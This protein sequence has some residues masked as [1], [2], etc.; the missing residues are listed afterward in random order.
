MSLL[1]IK[2]I[3]VNDIGSW[4]VNNG[5]KVSNPK[6]FDSKCFEKAAVRSGTFRGFTTASTVASTVDSGASCGNRECNQEKRGKNIGFFLRE[7]KHMFLYRETYAQWTKMAIELFDI[8]DISWD[9][10]INFVGNSHVMGIIIIYI[11]I[12]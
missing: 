12:V 4:M 1:K 8:G 10:N 3:L 7:L 5:W 2:M 6:G 9:F 11:Y